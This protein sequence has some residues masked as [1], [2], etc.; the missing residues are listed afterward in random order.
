MNELFVNRA[1]ELDGDDVEPIGEER[2]LVTLRILALE[3]PRHAIKLLGVGDCLFARR[4]HV[5]VE[6]VS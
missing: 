3:K 1:D 2:P 6:S 5:T 4:E